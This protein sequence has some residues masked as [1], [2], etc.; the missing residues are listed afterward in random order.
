[1][2]GLGFCACV[3]ATPS[4][5]SQSVVFRRTTDRFIYVTDAGRSKRSVKE[6]GGG[7]SAQAAAWWDTPCPSF[8][9]SMSSLRARPCAGCG[10]LKVYSAAAPALESCLRR[11]ACFPELVTAPTSAL[12][13]CERR[14]GASGAGKGGATPRRWEDSWSAG[15]ET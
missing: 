7:V 12:C 2:L 13:R 15:L 6:R 5:L 1:M 11:G 3:N 10:G 14:G 9:V 8:S 4:L